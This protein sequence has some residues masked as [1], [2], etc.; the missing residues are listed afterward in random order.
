MFKC[1][2]CEYKTDTKCNL[3][4][5]YRKKKICDAVTSDT[6]IEDCIKKLNEKIFECNLCN[7]KFSKKSHYIK[8][9]NECKIKNH[10]N[11]LKENKLKD[12]LLNIQN[13]LINSNNIRKGFN[14]I[15]LDVNIKEFITI[16][17]EKDTTI[18]IKIIYY[19]KLCSILLK[20]INI[21][22]DINESNNVK[23]L[24]NYLNE[25]TNIL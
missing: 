5:H 7:N 24:S 19:K 25:V 16:I 17:S 6:S 23:I 8:H 4:K 11:V 22:S 3:V 1:L 14:R 10:E 9:I 12:I 20:Y 15:N 13:D 18:Q 2:R 21:N